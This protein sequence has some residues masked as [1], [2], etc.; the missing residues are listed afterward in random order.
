MLEFIHSS[1]DDLGKD[2][3][4]RKKVRSHAMRDFRHRQRT[5][6]GNA[7]R[8]FRGP[9]TFRVILP[10]R[11]EDNVIISQA[12]EDVEIA[13]N[14]HSES[15]EQTS[16]YAGSFQEYQHRPRVTPMLMQPPT[17]GDDTNNPFQSPIQVSQMLGLCGNCT[18]SRLINLS[19][20][21][22]G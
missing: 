14:V 16:D 7:S 4:S 5:Q 13:D 8:K 3:D 19:T 15:G 10:R 22:E 11:A 2:V 9:R 6:R 1:A 17:W 12:G 18:Q 20:Y 21:D